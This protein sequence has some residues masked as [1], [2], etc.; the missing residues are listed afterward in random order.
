VPSPLDIVFAALFAVVFVAADFW[1]FERRFKR[2]VAAGVPNARRNAYRHTL[3]A[4]WVLAALV[5]LLWARERRAWSAMGLAVP[6]GW[7]LLVS[8]VMVVLTVVLVLRQNAA[9]RR[10]SAERKAKLAARFAGLEY[11]MPRTRQ[12]YRWFVALSWTAGICEELLYRGFLTWLIA[13]YLGWPAILVAAAIFGLGHAYQGGKGI[14]KTGMVGLV[15]GLVVLASGWLVPAMVI[16]ALIDVASGTAA[17][18]TL[19]S[20]S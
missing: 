3:G 4:L 9:I 16:H 17:F 7:R 6:H 2:Q 19:R 10:L 14:I 1:Y 5:V 18:V 20:A 13:S 12:E 11:L 8:A 15:M